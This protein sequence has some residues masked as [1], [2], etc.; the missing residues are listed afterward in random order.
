MVGSAAA[1]TAPGQSESPKKSKSADKKSQTNPSDIVITGY[2]LTRGSAG[3]LIDVRIQEVPR[4]IQ[5][6]TEPTLTNQM[7]SNTLDVIKLFPGVDRGSDSPGGEHPRI[8]GLNAFQYLEGTFSGNVIWDSAEFLGSAEVLR[9]PNSIQFGFLSSGGGTINYRLKRPTANPFLDVSTKTSNWG[10]Y[11][12]VLDGN[13]P[14]GNGNGI[15]VIAVHESTTGYLSSQALGHR[16]SAAVMLTLADVAGFKADLDAEILRRRTPR[17]PSFSFSV[18]PT[19]PLP[20]NYD[21]RTSTI[22]PWENLSRTGKRVNARIERG[23]G[24][25]WHAVFTANYE[26]QKVLSEF[27]NMQDPNFTTGETQY[28]CDT[29]GFQTYSN[30][31][32]RLDLL[33]KFNTFGLQHDF[34]IGAS[35]LKQLILLPNEFD[36]FYAPPYNMQNIYTPRYYPRPTVPSGSSVFGCCY[37]LTQWWTQGYFQDRITIARIVEAWVGAN[38]GQ[39]YNQGTSTVNG[40]AVK[41]PK[42]ATYSGVSPAFSLAVVPYQNLRLYASYADQISPGS[43]VPV[44]P[45]YVNQGQHFPPL[46]LKSTE[47]G[48][49]WE[50]TRG[51][52]LN[53]NAFKT[54]EPSVYIQTVGPNLFRY[55]QSGLAVFKGIELYSDS[56]FDFGLHLNGGIVVE[57]AIKRNTGNPLL[58]GQRK[59]SVP[60]FNATM[61]AEYKVPGL[62][63]LMFNG[64]IRHRSSSPLLE[65]GG[66]NV[67]GNTVVDLGASYEFDKLATPITL[68]AELNNAFAA[69]YWS[70]YETT[71]SPGAPRTLWLSAE[72]RFGKK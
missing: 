29:F 39:Y 71:I 64:L 32:L 36:Q 34:A 6:I 22:Q 35:Q 41:G 23:L 27:C 30:R 54:D 55:S 57:S 11:K 70:P 9:G 67:P 52:Y 62:P 47:L 38:Y 68:R 5:V 65:T 40:A 16:D 61:L 45:H 14:F 7:V 46:R 8:R 48:V 37:S 53:F 51:S 10:D 1:Q 58:D 24:S 15:R 13:Q 20:T 63:Q 19:T 42:S 31:S 44:D 4:A 28:F 12:Y 69:R 59:A 49:K 17:T 3:S 66:F 56:T 21:P 72:V 43:I 25:G 33:G 2:R 50:W 60:R 18:N 26:K